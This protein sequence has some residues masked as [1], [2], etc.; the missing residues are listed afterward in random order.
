MVDA[1][2][3]YTALVLTE[4][5]V[6][7]L[8][9]FLKPFEVPRQS[10]FS[11]F[12]NQSGAPYYVPTRAESNPDQDFGMD[13]HNFTRP[14]DQ[15]FYHIEE[16]RRRGI[17]LN[18]CEHQWYYEPVRI[19]RPEPVSPLLKLAEQA[20]EADMA[21]KN[22]SRTAKGGKSN[23]KAQDDD[24][25]GEL[26]VSD[27]DEEDDGASLVSESTAV[28][29]DGVQ[30]IPLTKE[31]LQQVYTPDQ[32]AGFQQADHTG[33]WLDF[34][35]LQK[36]SVRK[37][38]DE[39]YMHII[40]GVCRILRD[41]LDFESCRNADGIV[42]KVSNGGIECSI[43][44]V[45]LRKKDIR[46]ENHHKYGSCYKDSFHIRIP[47]IK[48]TRGYKT[49]LRNMV[50]DSSELQQAL[51]E[52]SLVNTYDEIVDA[53][54][55]HASP[56]LLGC[57]KRGGR[58][59]HSIYKLYTATIRSMDAITMVS[60]SREFDPVEV[61]EGTNTPV[62]K[63]TRKAAAAAA[64]IAKYKWNLVYETSL[65]Y[66]NPDGLIKKRNFEPKAELLLEIRSLAE[67]HVP[68]ITASSD[69]S[70]IDHAVKD[71]CRSNH[72]AKFLMQ[73][74]DML[75]P[76]RAE[77]YQSW[78]R[79]ILTLAKEGPEYK[80]LAIRFSQ[81]APT[82]WANNGSAALEKLWNYGLTHP[83][84]PHHDE[85]DGDEA[86]KT[87]NIRTIYN[88]A[89]TD[90]PEAYRKC[91]GESAYYEFFTK[92]N[93]FEG[94]LNE[95]HVGDI[96][97]KIFGN[98]FVT[99]KVI[100]GAKGT[101]VWY[102]FVTPD[103]K[104]Q[105][106]KSMYKWR[107]EA[108]CPDTFDD[109]LSRTFP[110]YINKIITHFKVSE[111]KADNDEKM[112]VHYQ[113]TIKNLEAMRYSLGNQ[114]TIDKYIRRASRIF[115]R[116]DFIETLDTA[117]HV[118]GTMNGVLVLSPK[119][120]LV[121][122]YNDYNI[123]RSV[124]V[125]YVQIAPSVYVVND[126]VKYA[127][128]HDLGNP[129]K[130]AIQMAIE[131]IFAGEWDAMEFN[132]IYLASAMDHKKKAP[133]FVI[134]LGG[135]ANGKSFILE[136]FI[137]VMGDVTRGGY[138]YKINASFFTSGGRNNNGPDSQ[139]MG[140]QYAR[141]TYCSETNQ[142]DKLHT[143]IIKEVTSDTISGNEKFKTQQNFDVNTRFIL[144]TNH[145]T[146]VEGND[147]GIWR[148]LFVYWFKV[149][150]KENPDPKNKFERKMDPRK[151]EQWPKDRN[152]K[153]AFFSYMVDWYTVYRDKYHSN[154]L[155][156][157]RPTI[158]KES[159]K[160]RQDSD[161]MC[162]F[163]KECLEYVGERYYAPKD[164]L[165]GDDEPE[166]IV[167]TVPI[168]LVEVAARYSDWYKANVD[169]RDVPPGM[170]IMQQLVKYPEIDKYVA[171]EGPN[172]NTLLLTKHILHGV[173]ETWKPVKRVIEKSA[174]TAEDGN[175]ADGMLPLTHHTEELVVPE[176]VRKR[177]AIELGDDTDEV[178]Q[179]LDDHHE[180]LH[181]RGDNIAELA[182]MVFPLA[183]D[184]E[185]L[186]LKVAYPE[187]N[188]REVNETLIAKLPAKERR[189]LISRLGSEALANVE[190]DPLGE[191]DE[192]TEKAAAEANEA[193]LDDDEDE[194]MPAVTER[195][196]V[197]DIARLAASNRKP[198]ASR[199]PAASNKPKSSLPAATKLDKPSP[200]AS[201]KPR[202]QA[203]KPR[204]VKRTA[205]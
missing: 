160:F 83:D 28:T 49:Y 62:V 106:H 185:E 176:I 18:F 60:Q 87:R 174:V 200:K 151:I 59:A 1:G 164:E 127:I 109:C 199:K 38:G 68:G 169:P 121:Q 140:L 95:T 157:P 186:E 179:E 56:M 178:P 188:S 32:L 205:V 15:F 4:P 72:E 146:R 61:S 30:I 166:K 119:T 33:I 78:M 42:K 22:P 162:K 19:V 148:R 36:D 198:R 189:E 54:V 11:N 101:R 145:P 193:Y 16:C 136:M 46:A 129:Y 144:A 27:D 149:T 126:R 91:R 79:I 9:T 147:H 39:A 98:K 181:S 47:T 116:D 89:A 5:T 161:V 107:Y 170:V 66:E 117:E 113:N 40:Q 120:E 158:D 74:L 84:K 124:T 134:W 108:D 88:M 131:E 102:S 24:E 97:E 203:K 197:E 111:S 37:L 7:V 77:N 65:L 156:V 133:M 137:K 48:V 103:R 75:D 171:E 90:N 204:A 81:R 165:E 55:V 73:C 58:E 93:E 63:K 100:T 44:I 155:N 13:H 80:P 96:L 183:V 118:I 143:S 142:M 201:A 132:M 150:F 180:W 64:P 168:K 194:S 82:Q 2:V 202:A 69:I 128:P 17:L 175:A 153:Q 192:L 92:A 25:F 85:I 187:F 99:D 172:S 23:R 135:G 130:Q 20:H 86:L 125:D 70:L 67:R 26:E 12:I 115:R 139:K 52:L 10:K 123:T 35:I 57:C 6:Q 141:F 122:A 190:L 152:F 94:K 104:V 112:L 154:V 3:T 43:Y 53:G 71:L 195:T 110:E 196:L 191:L 31:E 8:D 167:D 29:D 41:S 76:K 177:A 173:G 34:D 114:A 21:K 138:G 159:L 50:R 182:D 163:I 45:L 14:I 184:D 105:S 51:R